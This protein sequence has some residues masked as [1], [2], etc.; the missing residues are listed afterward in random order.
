MVVDGEDGS[1]LLLLQSVAHILVHKWVE[2]NVVFLY[3]SLDLFL[4]VFFMPLHKFLPDL[5]SVG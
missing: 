2:A 4:N 5:F 3:S 1:C